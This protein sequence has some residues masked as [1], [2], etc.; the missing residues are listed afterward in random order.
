MEQ[1]ELPYDN[2]SLN[3][4]TDLKRAMNLAIKVSGLT[5]GD[6]ADRMN[7][8]IVVERLRTRG[9]DGLITEDMVNKWLAPE[10]QEIIPTKLIKIF[11]TVTQSG[12]PAQTLVPQGHRVIGP[13]EILFL[14][15]GKAYLEGKK[16][17]KRTRRLAE[18]LEEMGHDRVRS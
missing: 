4:T 17:Q 6:I 16:F 10:G 8:H 2:K 18:Q 11:G 14:E 3:P 5:R 7:E 15:F 13:K 1:K 12:G 9:R